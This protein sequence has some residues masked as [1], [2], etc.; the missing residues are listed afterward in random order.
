M[1]VASC[2]SALGSDQKRHKWL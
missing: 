2:S 1:K